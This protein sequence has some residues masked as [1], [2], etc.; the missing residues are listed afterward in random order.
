[1]LRRDYDTTMFAPGGLFE[2]V[3][4][5]D[6]T[7]QLPPPVE[8]RDPRNMTYS[9]ETKYDQNQLIALMNQAESRPTLSRLAQLNYQAALDQYKS[10]QAGRLEN[11]SMS[12]IMMNM[13]EA[14]LT[15]MFDPRSLYANE[16]GYD[17]LMYFGGFLVIVAILILLIPV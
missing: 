9:G 6:Q 3:P 11:L 15:A 7:S 14:V 12:Q 5:S 16:A 17:R 13:R 10:E 1:M 2:H 8:I 4:T